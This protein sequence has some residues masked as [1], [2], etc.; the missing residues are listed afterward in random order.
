MKK[1]FDLCLISIV[2]SFVVL[3]AMGW[4][5]NPPK[6]H[7]SFQEGNHTIPTGSFTLTCADSDDRGCTRWEGSFN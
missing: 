1:I 4:T 6:A 5:F 3:M 7:A 2:T